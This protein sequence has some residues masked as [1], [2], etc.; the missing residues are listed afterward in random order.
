MI[1]FSFEFKSNVN[2]EGAVMFSVDELAPGGVSEYNVSVS[3][4][5]HGLYESTR[6]R[7]RY[8]TGMHIDDVEDDIR[9]D[10]FV[11]CILLLCFH[12]NPYPQD[13]LQHL[14]GPSQDF[15]TCRVRPCDI[16]L[17]EGMDRLCLTHFGSHGR[18]LDAL[19]QASAAA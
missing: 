2:A 19:P 5:L 7:V 8:N 1:R 17:C 9:L 14:L 13:W 12:Q 15:V 18:T 3:A 11:S 16:L 10:H 4:K 6:A